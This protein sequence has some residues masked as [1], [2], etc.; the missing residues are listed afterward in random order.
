MEWI[1]VNDK[2]PEFEQEVLTY[3]SWISGDGKLYHNY[4]SGTL[5]EIRERMSSNGK[6]KTAIWYTDGNYD[7][8]KVTHWMP[9]S[10]PSDGVV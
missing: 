9:L 6:V 4:E 1:S 2:L 8:D 3:Y 7:N 10:P 5:N